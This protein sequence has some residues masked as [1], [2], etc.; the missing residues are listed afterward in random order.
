MHLEFPGPNGYG[1]ALWISVNL[2]YRGGLDCCETKVKFEYNCGEFIC[3][4][5]HI[6]YAV[7]LEQMAFNCV[8]G[9][10]DCRSFAVIK[11]VDR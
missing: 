7:V 11:P 6:I 10:S 9:K 2:D 8:Q 4:P 1:L 3:I 5:P